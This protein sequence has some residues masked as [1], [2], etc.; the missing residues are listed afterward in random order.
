[1]M[2]YV[3]RLM[4]CGYTAERA[5]QICRDFS[6]NLKVYDLELFVESVEEYWAKNHVE[7]A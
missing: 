7:E 1:M 3:D 2:E 4:N 5:I 6:R